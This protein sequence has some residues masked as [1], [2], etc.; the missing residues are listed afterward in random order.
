MPRFLSTAPKK[1]RNCQAAAIKD[2]HILN[3]H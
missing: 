2:K 1:T 3:K